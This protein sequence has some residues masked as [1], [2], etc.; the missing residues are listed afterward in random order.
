MT[1]SL[2][3]PLLFFLLQ[4]HLFPS[5]FSFTTATSLVRRRQPHDPERG[6]HRHHDRP[7]LGGI[8]R[9][10]TNY[11]WNPNLVTTHTRGGCSA[12]GRPFQ[13]ALQDDKGNDHVND[14][15]RWQ[16][17][18]VTKFV[19]LLFQGVT[20]PFP[21]LRR[22][23]LDQAYNNG[24]KT[25][26][27]DTKRTTHD[28][29]MPK[30]IGFSL[31]ECIVAIVLYLALGVVSYSSTVLQK[32]Q[33]WSFVDALY[34]GVVTFTSV[35]YGDL[36][37]TTPAG[38]LF[39]VL[40]GLSGISILGIAIAAIGSRFVQQENSMIQAAQDASRKRLMGFFHSLSD[41]KN[42][43][44]ISPTTGTLLETDASPE[45]TDGPDGETKTANTI[46]KDPLREDKEGL[47]STA[48]RQIPL[49][50]QTVL[51][52]LQRSLPAFTTLL[53]GGLLMGQLEGWSTIDSVYYTFI[54]AGTLGYGDFSPL[55]RRGRIW[56]IV[57][58]PLAVSAAGEVL[59]NV[60]SALL[61][62][63]QERFYKALMDQ[64]LD[65]ERLIEMDTDRNGQVSREEYVEFMLKEMKLVSPDV[66]EELHTQFHKLDADGGGYLD[67]EDLRILFDQQ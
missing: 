21:T 51:N 6:W 30:Q 7:Q 17:Q 1:R 44:V 25:A 36:C 10:R 58:I 3:V 65:V 49:W 34:F 45:T 48:S 60:A 24:S 15:I 11:R 43:T 47:Q 53:V 23:L 14:D 31:R 59:G 39:T 20:L 41:Q 61:E 37:P 55:T 22:L 35:G 2:I 52:L 46:D 62:R 57:F 28:D 4:S 42:A 18:P 56:A 64:K 67:K 13:S 5:T 38:K 32:D 19:R 9:K 29:D 54:T 12:A 66:F 63:R 50:R 16:T 8:T 33:C 27:N 26:D 40:F